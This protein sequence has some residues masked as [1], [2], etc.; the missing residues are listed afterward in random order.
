[1]VLEHQT[2][3]HNAIAAANY[4]TRMAL[5]QSYQMNEL[6]ERPEGFVSESAQRRIASAAAQVLEHLLF[7][8]EFELTDKVVG[9]TSFAEEF[10]ARG[11]CDSQGRSLREFDLQ[12]RLFKYP[13]SYLIYSDAFA[14][15]PKQV[16]QQILNKLVAILDGR[17]LSEEYQHLCS[18]SKRDILEILCD[19]LPEVAAVANHEKAA[20]AVDG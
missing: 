5:H 14:G 20:G 6:L 17:D 19:T 16:R 12:T 1:M 2:Q 15:L 10:T 7:C 3:M 18:R 4:E 9:S 8:G 13:C 11:E